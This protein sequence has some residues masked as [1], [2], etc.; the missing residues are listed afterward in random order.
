MMTR[1]MLLVALA[2]L[3]TL[4]LAAQQAGAPLYAD[5]SSV[6]FY[7]GPDGAKHAVSSVADWQRRREH[8]LANMQLVTGPLPD[9]SRKVPLDIQTL[10]RVELPR[11]VRTKILY[12]PEKGDRVPAYLFVPQGLKGRVPAML[13]LHQTIA[14]GKGEPAG[15]SDRNDPYALELAERGYVT[16]APDYPNYGDYKC[17]P[18]AMGYTSATMKGIWNHMRAVDVLESLAEVDRERIGAIGHSLGGHNAIFVAVFDPRIKAVVTSCGFNAFGKYYGGDLAGWSHRGYMPRIAERYGKD[19]KRMPFDF[20]ELVAAL[21]PRAFFTNSPLGDAN[22]EK[23]GVDDCL[24][25]AAPVYELFGARQSLVAVHPNCEHSFPP[26]VRQAA[27][28]FL[29]RVFR[30]QDH[31]GPGRLDP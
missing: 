9:A 3:E 17:D 13:C 23:S 27:Y 1:F 15:V 6:M 24:R 18:Y 10:Q 21:A 5:K 4:P 29:D 8:I 25:A 12:S 22:F 30:R 31:A 28:A 26:D 7:L 20:T 14:M 11:A 16:L 2:L 19:P